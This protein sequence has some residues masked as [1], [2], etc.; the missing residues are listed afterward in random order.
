M[1][2]ITVNINKEL[3]VAQTISLQQ[4]Q[5]SQS[6]IWFF[7]FAKAEGLQFARGALDTFPIVH[8]ATLHQN[9]SHQRISGF[10]GNVSNKYSNRRSDWGFLDWDNS[11]LYIVCL[12]EW[13]IFICTIYYRLSW[14]I[15]K[16]D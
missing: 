1:L 15:F 3:L 6:G 5:R 10:F 2:C 4:S 11:V 12:L 14:L 9:L 16:K 8:R 7:E 13:I